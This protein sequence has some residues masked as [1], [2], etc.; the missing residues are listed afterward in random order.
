MKYFVLERFEDVSG[1][2]GLGIIAEGI[3]FSDGTVAYRWLSDIATTVLADNI[4]I[5]EKL[6]GHDRK[7]KL[8][9]LVIQKDL[10]KYQANKQPYEEDVE[11][12]SKIKQR[13]SKVPF[14]APNSG[15]R[16]G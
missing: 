8:R 1:I 4:D 16:F 7:T 3:I 9:Y 6:H 15:R 10:P 12:P 11:E 2:S 14:N 5:V 13:T